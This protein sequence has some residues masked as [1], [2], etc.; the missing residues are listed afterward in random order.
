MTFQV[1]PIPERCGHFVVITDDGQVSEP[2]TL[3]NAEV[4]ASRCIKQGF[5]AAIRWEPWAK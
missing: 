1:F 2:M 3:A 4:L 5:G